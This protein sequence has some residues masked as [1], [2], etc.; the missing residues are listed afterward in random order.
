LKVID[1]SP[2]FLAQVKG[3]GPKL[4]EKIRRSWAENKG[5]REVMVFL[6][7]YKIGT[8]RA[9]KI[10]RYYTERGEDPIAAVKANPYRLITDIWGVG[11]Q[12]ADQLALEL[13][14]QR[15]SPFRA[16]AAVRH[17]LQEE[18]GNGHVG[19][20]EE[21]L[22]ERAVSMTD[23]P[24][25]GIRDAVEQLRIQDEI[26]RDSAERG[27]RNAES[28]PAEAPGGGA[29]FDSEFRI[30]N[31]ELLFLKP[32]FLAE[33]GVARQVTALA[34]GPHPLP[35]VNVDAALQW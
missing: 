21:L 26:V 19:Y 20:P 5:V 24:P 27:I 13:G 6:Q 31:S 15:D 32:L 18:A 29:D 25:V 7:S 1:E 17:V 33:L 14:L 30:P 3:V 12:T 4:I 22:L 2:A 9:L 16:Q 11:F 34:R 23:I 28:K 35:A 8:A 10:Y